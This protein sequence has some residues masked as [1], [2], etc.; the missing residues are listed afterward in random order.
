MSR[1]IFL[2][3]A[4]TIAVSVGTFAFV[5]PGSLLESKGVSSIEAA[6]WTREV[7]A[8]LI[9]IGIIAFLVRNHQDSPTLKVLMLGNFIAQ[10]GLLPI[11]LLAY[12][13][14][15]IS[16]LA[17][18]VPN[19]VIHTLLAAGFGYFFVAMKHPEASVS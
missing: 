2:T 16:L 18:I 15:T 11:E 7:G 19:T 5:L 6:I 17:G 3:L 13:T 1:T 14:G 12:Q 9:A 4:A 8:L 10:L